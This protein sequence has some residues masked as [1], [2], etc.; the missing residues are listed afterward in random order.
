MHPVLDREHGLLVATQEKPLE[1][2]PREVRLDR[3]VTVSCGWKLVLIAYEYDALR[4]Q[5]EWNEAGW[6]DRLAC[7]VHDQV[8]DHA[9]HSFKALDSRHRQGRADDWSLENE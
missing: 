2:T 6:L 4:I 9:S 5:I 3:I 8:V 1:K 7:L